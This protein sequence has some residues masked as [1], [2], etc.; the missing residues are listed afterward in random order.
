MPDVSLGIVLGLVKAVYQILNPKTHIL[1]SEKDQDLLAH[2]DEL[3]NEFTEP[4]T[5]MRPESVS[6]ELLH[7]RVHFGML[8]KI[9][10]YGEPVSKMIEKWESNEFD[11]EKS[12]SET[13]DAADQGDSVKWESVQEFWTRKTNELYKIR[14][15][16]E[17]EA[18]SADR[19]ARKILFRIGIPVFIICG[20]GV[21]YIYSLIHSFIEYI[22]NL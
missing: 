7:M 8:Q 11:T 16:V 3:I 18:L 9:K 19:R 1:V 14:N 5:G 4:F 13:L 15:K 12:A 10:T 6:R 22:T 21:Y 20:F 2:M 17:Y